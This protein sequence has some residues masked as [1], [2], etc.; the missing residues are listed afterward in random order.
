MPV[1]L[2]CRGLAEGHRS[3][4][5][6]GII[7]ARAGWSTNNSLYF[8]PAGISSQIRDSAAPKNRFFPTKYGFSSGI[9]TEEQDR[10]IR[11]APA[12]PIPGASLFARYWAI[13]R[14]LGPISRLTQGAEQKN[15]DNGDWNGMWGHLACAEICALQF[16][17]T[18][19]NLRFPTW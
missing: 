2:N 11:A 7:A 6:R 13:R 19:A 1:C 8:R 3:L 10:L 4:S 15:P 16:T 12:R 14:R 17:V 9:D 5:E 18:L